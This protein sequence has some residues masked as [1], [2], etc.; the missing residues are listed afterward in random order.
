MSKL[1]LTPIKPAH[2]FTD[3][4]D[5]ILFSQIFYF[6]YFPGVFK[7]IEDIVHLSEIRNTG[8][9]ATVNHLNPVV[10]MG[11]SITAPILQPSISHIFQPKHYSEHITWEKA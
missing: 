5:R 1:L 2:I 9:V 3:Q 7:F 6:G 4:K 8:M 11:I 10:P